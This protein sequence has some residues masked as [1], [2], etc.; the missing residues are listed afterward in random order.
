MHER[1]TTTSLAKH[2]ALARRLPENCQPCIIALA[3]DP[4]R[5]QRIETRLAPDPKKFRFTLE[6]THVMQTYSMLCNGGA[7]KT[8][9]Q[10]IGQDIGRPV[11][12]M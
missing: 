1:R 11:G 10:P 8:T 4:R 2:V 6:C 12:A 7:G 5:F 9:K 3:R